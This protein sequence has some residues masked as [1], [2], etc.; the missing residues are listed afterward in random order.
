M[1]K[2]AAINGKHLHFQD[3]SRGF[4]LRSFQ[5]D[6]LLDDFADYNVQGSPWFYA[7]LTLSKVFAWSEYLYILA[8][9]ASNWI[10]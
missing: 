7:P 9:V 3:C 5:R 4:E 6:P 2:Q 1:I 8:I 10:N